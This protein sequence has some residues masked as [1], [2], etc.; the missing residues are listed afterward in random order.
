MDWNKI[1]GTVIQEDLDKGL[2]MLAPLPRPGVGPRCTALSQVNLIDSAEKE[3]SRGTEPGRPLQIGP[4]GL[5]FQ[6]VG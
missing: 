4:S 5:E 2:L 3:R 6:A 1:K